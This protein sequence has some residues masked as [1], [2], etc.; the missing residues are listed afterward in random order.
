MNLYAIRHGETDMG[1]ND[2]VLKY[3]E[4]ESMKIVKFIHIV[5]SEVF[6]FSLAL[7]YIKIDTNG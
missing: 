7:F 2:S 1:K 5:A 4:T 3:P 6:Y